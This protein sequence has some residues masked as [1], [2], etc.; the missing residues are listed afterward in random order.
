[1]KVFA[2]NFFLFLSFV[3]VFSAC[4]Q[5]PGRETDADTVSN[6]ANTTGEKTDSKY[7]ALPEKIALAE[8]ENLDRTKTKI[9]D[10]KGKVLLLNL[11]ATWCGFCRQEMPILVKMQDAHRDSGFEI[12][13]LNVDDESIDQVNEFTQEMKLNYT[14]V[15]SDESTTRE[16]LKVSKFQG[17]PQSFLVDREGNLRGVFTGADPANLKKM[18]HLVA[19]IVAE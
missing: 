18:E 6:T 2:L 1:M 11:W 16:L 13:G 9:A 12:L 7:P 10:H 4:T 3:I 19:K 17:I 8:L 14:L 15:W 5:Q